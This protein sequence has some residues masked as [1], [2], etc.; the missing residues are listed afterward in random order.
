MSNANIRHRTA[1]KHGSVDAA[2][3][4]VHI[5][6]DCDIPKIGGIGGGGGSSYSVRQQH[7]RLHSS[8]WGRIV[9]IV[10]SFTIVALLISRIGQ[11]SRNKHDVDPAVDGRRGDGGGGD[12]R[13]VGGDVVPKGGGGGDGSPLFVT[14]V[15]PR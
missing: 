13:V 1:A 10:A 15:M 11:H 3:P 14:V 2:P 9:A 12:V 4:V 6:N 8:V 7:A 5:A